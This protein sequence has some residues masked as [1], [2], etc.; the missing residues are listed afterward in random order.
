MSGNPANI[1]LAEEVERI[2]AQPVSPGISGLGAAGNSR[3]DQ[4]YVLAQID[5][6]LKKMG[7]PL[8]EPYRRPLSSRLKQP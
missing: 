3:N 7:I 5:K 1:R 2:Q 4:L 6:A 8:T